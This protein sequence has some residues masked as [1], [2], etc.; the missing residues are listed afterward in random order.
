M[1]KQTKHMLRK[2]PTMK[3][4]KTKLSAIYILNQATQD[5]RNEKARIK[6]KF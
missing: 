3:T 2:K 4:K 1:E 6:K 5:A